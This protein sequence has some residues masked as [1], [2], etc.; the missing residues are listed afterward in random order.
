MSKA[1][2][3]LGAKAYGSIGHLPD[4]SGGE[5]IWNWQPT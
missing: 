3:P 4:V 2:K 1:E 5:P